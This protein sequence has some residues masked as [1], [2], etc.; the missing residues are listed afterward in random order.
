MIVLVIAS[1]ARSIGVLARGC[2]SPPLSTTGVSGFGSRR[3]TASRTPP[4]TLEA[5]FLASRALML[6]TAVALLPVL[7]NRRIETARAGA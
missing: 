7:S 5:P 3:G 4:I 6:V 1:S 2:R